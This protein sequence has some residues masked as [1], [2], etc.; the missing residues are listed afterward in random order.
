[1]LTE[2]EAVRLTL[3]RATIHLV[4]AADAVVLRPL[5]QHVIERIH[6]GAFARR[7]AGVDTSGA[8]S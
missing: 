3:M 2:R 4:T 7:L 6:R 1:M 8:R 5:L